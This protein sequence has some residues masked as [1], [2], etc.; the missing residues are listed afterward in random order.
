MKHLFGRHFDLKKIT[1]FFEMAQLAEK[2]PAVLSLNFESLRQYFVCPLGRS[3]LRVHHCHV[4]LM[5]HMA[6][7]ASPESCPLSAQG[8][9][10]LD[11]YLMTVRIESCGVLCNCSLCSLESH[12]FFALSLFPKSCL[13]CMK[14]CISFMPR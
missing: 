6:C 14:S 11:T 3:F 8:M 9:L 13:L 1:L 7:S 2:L 5:F 12:L 4:P 10:R